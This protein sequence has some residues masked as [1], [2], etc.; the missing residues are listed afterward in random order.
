MNNFYIKVSTIFYQRNWKQMMVA[1]LMV[2]TSSQAFSQTRERKWN[3]GLMGG[4]SVYAGDLGNSMT[5]FTTDVFRQNIIAGANFS[6]YL[7]RSFDVTLTST[8]G[9]FGYY[10]D[11]NT[12]FKGDMLHANFTLKYK[13]YNGY[14]TSEDSK[15]APYIFAGI[16]VSSFTGP[17]I[18]NNVD[19]P[20]VTGMGLRYRINDVIGITYQA[21]YGFMS[22]SHNN[23][24]ATD[25]Q[26]TGN[27]QF[28]MHTLGF[29][30]NLGKGK[31][32]DKDG[33]SD[34]K[35]KCLGTP[36][37]T[38]VDINGCPLDSDA[39]GVMDY[40]DKCPTLAGF[41]ATNGCPDTDKDG[42]AD[43]EDQC[44]NEPGI[45]ALK[46]CPDADGD[47]IIDSKDKCPNIKGALSL[48][49]CPDRDGDGIRDEEDACPDTK[50]TAALK[51]CPDTDGDGIEDSKDMCPQVK[52]P[53]EN[54][55]CPDTDNDG[56]H[57]G[58]DNCI[59]IPG[60]PANRGCPGIKKETVQLFE[61]A[62][63]G[64][65][66][67]TGKAIIKPVSF[68]I[69]NAI[70]KVMKDNPSYLLIIGGHTDNVGDD[71]MN[72]TLSQDRAS[73]VANYLIT[74][75]VGPMRVSANG[76]GETQPVDTN[77]S[78]KGK[79]RNRR[80]EFKVEFLKIVE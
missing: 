20:I 75:G 27:D 72:M 16:G 68:P 10:K 76:Y 17:F 19:M 52:G 3:A 7:N 70:V 42:V 2:V 14:F 80:V 55:G 69:L 37:G 43:N 65:Q 54:N 41:P 79:T 9:S 46:G 48:D 47:G 45:A 29:G 64:I 61:K 4:I 5:D 57:D 38:K 35:D 22:T 12:I 62:L 6:R 53:M 26:P 71:A 78:V 23:P 24:S 40:L 15:L 60:T 39:D 25:R 56:V 13:F 8:V 66:F 73:A 74:K 28:M 51:G 18:T 36:E 44:P 30:F 67:E 59:N 21:T 77:D 33:V 34:K 32:E 11:N 31:D 49:G 58:I 50:G 63:Q 1:L